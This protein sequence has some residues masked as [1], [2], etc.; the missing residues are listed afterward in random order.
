MSRTLQLPAPA[1][2]EKQIGDMTPGAHGL[3]FLPFLAGERSMGWN[4]DAKASLTGLHLDSSPIEIVRASMEAVALQFAQAAIRL[5]TLFP[6]ANR[7]IGSGGALSHSQTWCQMFADAIGSPLTLAAEPEASSRGA[8]L[9]AMDAVGIIHPGAHTAARL[10]KTV[11][12]DAGAHALYQEILEK[13]Q[14][15]Y[16]VLNWATGG[17]VTADLVTLS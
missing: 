6:H 7:I 3:T 5:R 15:I 17:I 1:E 9:L 4:P 11:E 8:A 10:G 13:Q 2:L 12:P 16:D 14:K